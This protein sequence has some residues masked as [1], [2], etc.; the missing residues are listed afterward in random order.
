MRLEPD[1]IEMLHRDPPGNFAVV[2]PVVAE[3]EYGIRRL[4]AGKKRSLLESQKNR[5]IQMLRVLDWTPEASV[6]FGTI[7]AELEAAGNLI[8]DFDV[9]IAAIAMTH[10]TGVITANTAHFSRIPGL[11]IRTW[12]A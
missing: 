3:I 8:D 12:P 5:F 9:A 2:P 4:P 10:D 1:L 11:E 7:K 6:R